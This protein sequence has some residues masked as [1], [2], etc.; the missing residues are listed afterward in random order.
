M[1]ATGLEALGRNAAADVAEQGGAAHD[2]RKRQLEREDRNESCSSDRPQNAVLQRARA[3]AMRRLHDDRRHR[4]LDAIEEARHQRHIAERDVDPRQHDE[5]HE[6]RQHEEAA[7]DDP[8]PGA[9]LQPADVGGQLL[10]LGARQHHA[11]VQRVQEAALGNPAPALDQLLVH[12]GDLPGRPA[13]ADEAELE[14]EAKRLPETQGLRPLKGRRCS[15][16]DHH[17]L[18]SFSNMT[19]NASN[20]APACCSNWS[21]SAMA[22]RRPASTRSTPCASG[23]CTPPTSR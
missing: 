11:V 3:D 9:M 7:G 23:G 2:Q 1:A 20:T 6:R 8:A 19:N 12:H 14:P 17:A 18:P 13:E 16:V 10:R 4:R 21:S 15:G 5:D 22:S